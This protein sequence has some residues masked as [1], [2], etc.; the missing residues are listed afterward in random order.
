MSTPNASEQ[1]L[2]GPFDIKREAMFSAGGYN[3]TERTVE[4]SFSSETPI[5]T[6]VSGQRVMEILGHNPDEVDLSVLNSVGP[7]LWMHDAKQMLGA[8]TRAW[9]SEDRKGRAVVKFSSDELGQRKAADVKDGILRAVSVGAE[10]LEYR[11]VGM[12]GDIP[13]LRATKWKPREISLLPMPADASVGV[14][15]EYKTPVKEDRKMSAETSTPP[16]V[17]AIERAAESK[18]LARLQS[19]ES[20]ATVLTERGFAPSAELRQKALSEG[21]N[22]DRL[23]AETIKAAATVK[24]GADTQVLDTMRQAEKREFLV[25]RAINSYLTKRTVDGFEGEV[26]AEITRTTGQRMP[27]TGILIPWGALST[28]SLL[29][30]SFAAGG[31]TVPVQMG[32]MINKLDPMPVVERAGATVFR[33]VSGPIVFPRQTTAATAQWVAEA[34]EVQK[35]TPGT[36]D[37]TLTPHGIAAYLEASRQLALSSSIDVEAWMRNEITKRIGLGIDKGALTGAGTAGVPRGAFALNTSTSGINTVS[38]GGAPTW[39]KITEFEGAVESDD[40]LMGNIAWI[41][42]APVK[43]KWK[44]TSKDTGSGQYLA[45]GNNANGYPIFVTSQLAS[46]S[47]ANRVLFGDFSQLYVAMFGALE[48]LIDSSAALQRKGLIGITGLA[49][50]DIGF[51]HPESFA[52]STD[53]GNQ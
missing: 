33:G 46:T 13:I 24:R 15:R 43:A 4:L 7:V 25:A 34:V 17:V 29:A 31:S 40:A 12:D 28:R 5:P 38:F 21:W 48:L 2:T 32:A 37:V 26:I 14:G 16:D 10:V 22:G 27:E 42:S 11:Q 50:A 3:E 39:A 30:G 35:S 53:A 51:A 52:V 45:D 44:A 47:Y 36:D 19:I 9:V 49:M 8:V 1:I 18:A 6:V 20:A 23:Y 41:T